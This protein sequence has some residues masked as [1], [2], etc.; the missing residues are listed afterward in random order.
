[1]IYSNEEHIEKKR[2]QHADVTRFLFVLL[3]G[4]DRS[5]TCSY[6]H[7]KHIQA[8]CQSSCQPVGSE[9]DE[10]VD[11]RALPGSIIFLLMG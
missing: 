4:G 10:L 11:H 5:V 6:K 1:M 3:F 9:H 2:K 7:A 8:S